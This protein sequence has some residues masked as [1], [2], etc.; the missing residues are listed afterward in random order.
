MSQ[1]L[2]DSYSNESTTLVEQIFTRFLRGFSLPIG[3]KRTVAQRFSYFSDD[4]AQWIVA[5]LGN[6][7]SCLQNLR[8]LLFAIK[9]FYQPINSGSFQ[10]VLIEF[11]ES[12]GKHFVERLHL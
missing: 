7:S 12:L 2:N 4:S 9:S 3:N 8:D 11:L 6:G 5:M 10:Q 1:V